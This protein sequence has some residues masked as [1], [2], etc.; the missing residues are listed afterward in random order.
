M[1][2]R[3]HARV[4][5]VVVVTHHTCSNTS[6]GSSC[7]SSGANL[8][9]MET[10]LLEDCDFLSRESRSLK[11]P[12][13]QCSL[14]RRQGHTPPSTGRDGTGASL[15]ADPDTAIGSD[16]PWCS[17]ARKHLFF[18]LQTPLRHSG[19]PLHDTYAPRSALAS[20]GLPGLS[21]VPLVQPA[22]RLL[23]QPRAAIGASPPCCRRQGSGS[24]RGRTLP[25]GSQWCPG[26]TP[27][28]TAN[29][30]CPGELHRR[31]Q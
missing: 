27:G 4:L 3:A 14:P 24:S 28:S 19:A 30:A 23:A 18:P 26:S 12:G 7:L 31:H 13:W 25:P 16:Q 29:L 6:P 8:T 2:T 1:C 10:L 20:R 5:L 21:G 22:G 17:S 11:R 15:E 9:Q